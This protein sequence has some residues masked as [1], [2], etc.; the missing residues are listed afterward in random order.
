MWFK[1]AGATFTNNLGTMDSI[2]KSY[3]MDY[4]GLTGLQA[5]PG[6]VSYATDSTPDA[7]ITFTVKSG[8]VF[9][10]G[11]TVTAS[12]GASAVYTATSDISAGG[13]FTLTLTAINDK[14][15]FSGAAELVSGGG[16]S[17][18]GGGSEGGG[19]TTDPT[20]DDTYFDITTQ[21]TTVGYIRA[22]EGV[23]TGSGGYY[24]TKVQLPSNA[25]SVEY[26]AFPSGSDYG[27]AFMNDAEE[28]VQALVLTSAQ[29]SVGDRVTKSVPSGA[30][31]FYHMWD[32]PNDSTI[33]APAFTYI[34]VNLESEET[35]DYISRIT[36][37]NEDN[38]GLLN[39]STGEF[40]TQNYGS[41]GGQCVTVCDIPSGATTV[42]YQTFKTGSN[43]GSCFKKA[44]GTFI[45]GYA[46]KTAASGTRKTL[47]IPSEAATFWHMYP[48][49]TYATSQNMDVFNYIEFK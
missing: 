37:Q 42:N 48:D 18:G 32:N 2:S 26:Q 7:T 17:S 3:M 40:T 47:S 30:T 5:S 8:Y 41:S 6:S 27:S 39:A 14:V 49:S 9:K 43:Y 31:W 33:S 10:T 28:I 20:P 21:G 46:E 25:V 22:S 13:T 4:S 38:D 45:S 15:T 12:G 36:V 11:A 23:I 35:Q 1:L 44:D 29:V 24:L 34:R 19:E 16:S